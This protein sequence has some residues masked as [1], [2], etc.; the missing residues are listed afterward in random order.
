MNNEDTIVMQPKNDGANVK[1]N[2]ESLKPNE[3]ESNAKRA[4]ATATAGVFGG[5]VGGAGSVAAA[6]AIH[7]MSDD[8]EEVVAE[9]SPEN[10]IVTEQETATAKDAQEVTAEVEAEPDYTNH[11]GAD[12]VAETPEAQSTSNDESNE[13][14]VL[15]VYERYTEDGTHQEMA[16]LTNG[17]EMA[18]V[19]DVDGDGIA[20]VIGVDA[21]HDGQLQEGE[22]HDISA[23]GVDMHIYE[24]AY[25]AQQQAEQDQNDTFAYNADCQDD[26]NNDANVYDA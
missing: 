9:V 16:V 2:E 10:D 21:N 12:P 26:Y 13:V 17:E 23:H 5:A 19:V 6:N 4:F 20:D 8:E 24:G 18:A 3:K 7:S 25:M 14:Q 11:A 22:I 15:G 1:K